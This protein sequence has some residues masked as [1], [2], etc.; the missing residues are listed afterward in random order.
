[1][2]L[3][4]V[5]AVLGAGLGAY[6][7]PRPVAVVL[8]L[9]AAAGARGALDF[10][11][12][13]AGRKYDPP[14]WLEFLQAIS[15]SPSASYLSVLLAAGGGSLFAAVMCMFF[16]ETP[17]RPFWLPPEGGV[18][19]RDG[20]GRY[21]RVAD[22]IEERAIHAAAEARMHAAFDGDVRQAR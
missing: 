21:K 16:D 15:I 18:R 20:T 11:V 7:R 1:M 22:M 6:L 5:I 3:L 9:G 10:V 4:V 12:A 13:L 14:P 17:Y 19:A 2:I 8:S